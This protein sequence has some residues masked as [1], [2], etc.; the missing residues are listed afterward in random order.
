[1][2][3]TPFSRKR[4][5]GRA[6]RK[7]RQAPRKIGV[8]ERTGTIRS[9]CLSSKYDGIM[10]SC[11]IK[12]TR[13]YA[14]VYYLLGVKMKLT[15]RTVVIPTAVCALAIALVL[16]GST[17]NAVAKEESQVFYTEHDAAYDGSKTIKTGPAIS[18]VKKG[19]PVTV[20]WD[21]YGKDYWACYVR[22]QT[23]QRGWI[24]CTSLQRIA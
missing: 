12:M 6:K 5:Q 16:F 22:T 3:V 18:T 9:P 4:R 24:L 8:I 10:A 17:W 23:N 21:T 15:A 14:P 2:R 1:M 7:S 20:L 19:E 11:S 13:A